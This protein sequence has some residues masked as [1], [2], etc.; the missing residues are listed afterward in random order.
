MEGLYFGEIKKVILY[1][2]TSSITENN[3]IKHLI[4][5]RGI[6]EIFTSV[7]KN[8]TVNNPL[9]LFIMQNLSTRL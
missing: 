2:K 9:L 1:L 3:W 5:N 4:E 7:V 6:K 8:K